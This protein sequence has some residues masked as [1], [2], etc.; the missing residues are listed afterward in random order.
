MPVLYDKGGLDAETTKAVDVAFFDTAIQHD[1]D[2]IPS[3]SKGRPSSLGIILSQTV[4]TNVEF[5]L[6]FDAGTP[7]WSDIKEGVALLAN[8]SFEFLIPIKPKTRFNMRNKVEA[9]II[10]CEVIE[11]RENS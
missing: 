10:H 4:E 8:T 11:I 2:A 6:D 1:P 3:V 9:E 5:T 7:H